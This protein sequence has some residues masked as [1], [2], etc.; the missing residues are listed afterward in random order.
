MKVKHARHLSKVAALGCIVCR[1]HGFD[2]SPAEIH[3]IRA[4]Q[5]LKRASHYE[6]IPLC[7][8]HH[9]IGGYGIAFHAGKVAWEKVFGT[10]KELLATVLGLV[11][12]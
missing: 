2:D 4:G 1:N 10:E 7:P 11:G 5:G 3:H 6:T 8:T 12:A 9:R